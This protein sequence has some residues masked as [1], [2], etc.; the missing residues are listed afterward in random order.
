MSDYTKQ[1]KDALDII[2]YD[3]DIADTLSELRAKW[4]IPALRDPRLD[5]VAKQ[6][7]TL[8][9][10]EGVD[11]L[12]QELSS[13]GWLLYDL[14]GDD[15]Y[16]FVLIPNSERDEFERYCR[17][18]RQYCRLAAQRGRKVGQ[19]ARSRRVPEPMPADEYN[20]SE[21]HGLCRWHI[22]SFSGDWGA[23]VWR[24]NESKEWQGACVAELK[25][26]PPRVM[27]LSRPYGFSNLTRS[28]DGEL[29]A[30][31]AS[32]RPVGDMWVYVG[33]KPTNA[34][35]FSPLPRPDRGRDIDSDNANS[36]SGSHDTSTDDSASGSHNSTSYTCDR[37]TTAWFGKRL[38][39]GT[40]T[41]IVVTDFTTSP[42]TC[43]NFIVP[44]GDR[45]YRFGAD[46][47]GRV[48]FSCGEY[49]PDSRNR[50][51]WRWE[52]GEVERHHLDLAP[53]DDISNSIPFGAGKICMLHET[54]GN[55]IQKNLLLVDMDSGD[56]RIAN[57]PRLGENARISRL[58]GDWVLLMS[59]GEDKRLDL[60]QIW[61]I[62]TNELLRVTQD[63]FG[64]ER[65][66][67]ITALADGS[68]VIASL[69]KSGQILRYT[70]DFFDYLRRTHKPQRLESWRNYNEKYPYI[71][72]RLPPK[73]PERIFAVKKNGVNICGHIITPPFGLDTLTEALGP[74]RLELNEDI[75]TSPAGAQKP[76][77]KIFVVWDE[78]G[79]RGSLADDEQTVDTLTL[80]LSLSD[81]ANAR[82]ILPEREFSGSVRIGARD[83]R[84]NTLKWQK[85]TPNLY[86]LDVGGFGLYMLTDLNEASD[87]AT[88]NADTVDADMTSPIRIELSWQPTSRQSTKPKKTNKYRITK[89]DEPLLVFKNLNFKLAVV[90]HLMY[91]KGL[92]E[93]RFDAYEFAAEYTRRKIDIDSEGYESIPEILRWFEKLPVPAR[94][95]EYVT[96]LEMDGG[97][98]IYTQICPFWD[99]EDNRFSVDSIAESE[100]K[101]FPKLKRVTLMSSRPQLIIPLFE[102]LNIEV[103][104]L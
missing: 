43:N 17:D 33:N 11:A 30:A 97:D 90:Q 83:C 25:Y 82:K 7:I 27:K 88:G 28:P 24:G 100:L 79:L 15:I 54:S 5:S 35:M 26:R 64:T 20:I 51:L 1:I 92:L 52:D 48:Y 99:G 66:E 80:F 74:A 2:K 10:T 60:A 81:K 29:F 61:N 65:L 39:A 4:D 3:S 55:P 103:T 37:P 36:T 58:C 84:D 69:G 86:R 38:F 56:C 67:A 13:L 42:A 46:S 63:M 70:N 45:N 44:E 53:F 57:L 49:L 62:R 85:L 14:D 72:D 76:V 101:Q 68:I 93:P 94:L 32:E 77:L 89:P 41:N 21:R 96:E 73:P 50:V 23:G 98:E 8:P 40:R 87:T 71:P 12:G 95:A 31:T 6:Y 34:D 19:S 9:H 47:L 18:N 22:S 16:L 75:I 59:N 91:D 102:R 104:P 78:L